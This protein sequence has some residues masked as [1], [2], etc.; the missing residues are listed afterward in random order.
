MTTYD[1]TDTIGGRVGDSADPMV[2]TARAAHPSSRRRPDRLTVA[3]GWSAVTIAVLHTIVFAFHPHWGAWLAGLARSGD[4]PD[5]AIT[6][7]WALPG[8]FVVPLAVLGLLIIGTGRRG[9]AMPR[10]VGW[11]LF[12]WILFCFWIIGPSGFLLGLVPTALLLWP[13]RSTRQVGT[14]GT[15]R[16]MGARPA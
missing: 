1:T 2:R 11:M 3:A 16:R 8:G 14:R 10:Y 4:L 13:R 6:V 7:F 5:E 9:H 12:G 15:A